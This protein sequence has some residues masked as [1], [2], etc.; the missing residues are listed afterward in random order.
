M[1]RILHLD[2]DAFFASIEQQRRPELAGKPLVVGGRGD[3]TERG[4]VSTASYEARVFGIHSGMPLRT[5]LSL[6]P[7]AVFLPVDFRA[8]ERVA[9]RIRE[10]LHE[11]SPVVEEA[12]IDE[13]SSTWPGQSPPEEWPVSSGAIREET[14]LTCSVGIAPASCWPSLAAGL[15]KP[16]DLTL[17]NEADV[18]ERLWPLPVR[19]LPGVGPKTEERL[20][21][22][23]I[24][25]IGELAAAPPEGLVARFGPAH[26]TY[27]YWAARGVDDTPLVV[28]REP[29]SLSRETTFQQDVADL[30]TLAMVLGRQVRELST[31][32]Q[33]AG[34]RGK[35]VTVKLRYQNFETHTH[36]VTLGA[37][38]NRP[39]ALYAAARRCLDRF[40][41]R[42]KVRLPVCGQCQGRGGM[43]NP[44][45]A[46]S[47]ASRLRQ[48]PADRPGAAARSPPVGFYR[49]DPRG[50]RDR[51]SP[52]GGPRRTGRIHAGFGA[53]R[54]RRYGSTYGSKNS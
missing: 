17:L 44:P 54:G 2:M 41:L 33:R 30:P 35:R 21:A 50:A 39:A 18:P 5:A 25:T 43:K 22:L 11:V 24:A 27:L 3:P 14:G 34:W 1:R 6:C 40:P 9:E 47:P 29:H 26:G 36:A 32:L 48:D 19:R 16:D 37:A 38:T 42:R 8:Y 23:G 49:G 15:E 31:R 20:A 4:V 46:P 10:I 13:A 28:S 7:Q 51:V 12:G 45:P 53:G 52:G